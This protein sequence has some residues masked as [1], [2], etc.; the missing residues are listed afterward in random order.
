MELKY[1]LISVDDHVQET[2]DTWTSYMSTQ[3][4]GDLIPHLEEQADGSQ[5]WMVEGRAVDEDSVAQ[6]GA[7]MADRNQTPRRWDEVPQAA[8][9]PSQRLGAMDADGVDCQV[10]YPSVAGALR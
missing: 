5:V 7:I 9:V 1:G 6:T 4:W 8:Y 2:P 10:L 3:K